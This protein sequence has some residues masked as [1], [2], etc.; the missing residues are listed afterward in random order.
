MEISLKQWDVAY[1]TRTI[2]SLEAKI[3]GVCV[4][5]CVW[6]VC[7][8]CGVSVSVVCI[9]GMCGMCVYLCVE[10]GVYVCVGVCVLC[11]SVYVGCEVC[12]CARAHAN[13]AMPPFPQRLVMEPPFEGLSGLQVSPH[14]FPAGRGASAWWPAAR[15]PPWRERSQQQVHSSGLMF[16]TSEL[17]IW[18]EKG[19]LLTKEN[20]P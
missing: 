18:T 6:C 13:K 9:R 19:F 20:V 16:I 7:V 15:S 8:V 2:I 4:C 5:M 1:F 14:S 11:L 12:V 3:L 10:G 17:E